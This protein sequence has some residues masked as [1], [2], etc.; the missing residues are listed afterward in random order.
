M[1]QRIKGK[2]RLILALLAMTALFVPAIVM[3]QNELT[4]YDGTVGNYYVPVCASQCDLWLK[5]EYV[6]PADEL[7]DMNGKAITKLKYY[8][9]DSRFWNGMFKV[10]MMEVDYTNYGDSPSFH[11]L[12]GA[13]VV[14]EG[15]LGSTGYP[16]SFREIEL[17]DYYV[18]QGGNL[19]IGVYTTMPRYSNSSVRFYGQTVAGAS[20]QGSGSDANSISISQQNFIPK[21]TFTYI[22][23]DAC[24]RPRDLEYDESSFT[25]S[26]VVLD[27][28]PRGN[29]SSWKLQYSVDEGETWTMV[30]ESITQ[31]PY[32]WTGLQNAT[33]YRVRVCADCGNGIVSEGSSNYVEFFT[34]FC[35]PENQCELHY[36]LSSDDYGWE[37][38]S[39]M[40]YY[41]P[42]QGE[43]IFV[44]E[45][46]L[47]ESYSEG[48][49]F[50][51]D[52][53]TYDFVWYIGEEWWVEAC[54]FVIYGPDGNPIP[55]LDYSNGNLPTGESGEEITLLSDYVMNCPTCK[56]PQ[57]FS[58]TEV[59]AYSASFGWTAGNEESA[60]ELQYSTDQTN[61]SDT[62][63][64]T[65]TPSCS[66]ENLQPATKYYA[67]V[68]ANCG[69]GD[70]S[71]WVKLSFYTECATLTVDETNSYY[72]DFNS[73]I[74]YNYEPWMEGSK[75]KGSEKSNYYLPLCWNSL[76]LGVD[77]VEYY[78][79][80]EFPCIY[81]EYE[82][83][84]NCLKFYVYNY[85]DF[86][87][88]TL[89]QYAVLPTIENVSGLQLSFKAM[90]GESSGYAPFCIGVMTDPADANSFDTIR[91]FAATNE[92]ETFVVYFNHYTGEG[93][94]IAIKVGTPDEWESF[95]LYI[96]DVEVTVQP[97][98]FV[99]YKPEASEIE[100]NEVTLTWE[101]NGDE[102]SW[103]VRYSTDKTNWTVLE[104][105]LQ[106]RSEIVSMQL[107]D[108]QANTL[109]FVQ[110]RAKAG[111]GEYSEWSQM[112]KFRTACS[113]D[114]QAVP[115]YET[116][117]YYIPYEEFPQC[118]EKI[119]TSTYIYNDYPIL[120]NEEGSDDN[121]LYFYNF[122]NN[123][124]NPQDQ[125]AV[126]PIMENISNLQL[127][128]Y[129]MGYQKN[130][131]C[132][133]V[134]IG[135]IDNDD[136]FHTI[137]TVDVNGRAFSS[138][139][140]TFEDYDNESDVGRIAFR[141]NKPVSPYY[142]CTILID[143]VS[144]TEKVDY[145]TFV[146]A[147]DWNEAS[148][149]EN[150]T[151]PSP[152]DTVLVQA[153]AVIPSGCIAEANIID[154]DG[155]NA[156]L[157]IEEGGQLK[158]NGTDMKA[159]LEKTITGYSE[160]EGDGWYLIASP[161]AETKG[162]YYVDSLLNNYY[163]AK[164]DLYRY[165]QSK[166]EME[167]RNYK[168]YDDFIEMVPKSGYLYANQDGVTLY[169]TGTL[170]PTNVDQTVALDFTTG[171][172]HAGWN[173]VGNPFT[174]NAYVSSG[175]YRMN[176]SGTTLESATADT[177]IVPM[178][179][180][181]VKAS[182]VGQTATF[183]TTPTRSEGHL[184]IRLTG[185]DMRSVDNVVVSF[186][187]DSQLGKLMLNPE[188]SKLYFPMD[189]KEY[190]IVS[191]KERSELPLNFKANENG[192][193][194]ISVSIDGTKMN[195]LHLVDNLTGTDVDL[196]TTPVY[197]FDAQTTDNVSRFKLIFKDAT[198][199]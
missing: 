63:T 196:L 11:G 134:V 79:Y 53:G 82:I 10:F 77:N 86:E 58:V 179:G 131:Y 95:I 25:T 198:T 115:Y 109:Y 99:P 43:R 81:D 107:T 102:T 64:V 50:L 128:F 69:G 80:G 169:F 89:D 84:S 83:G 167:W 6:I 130:T 129:G 90:S 157:T 68:R 78:D 19:L 135:V 111:E 70:Y 26:S 61:W 122:R 189:D 137:K 193:Y 185:N 18:Y 188:D 38:N 98:Y 170:F 184:N 113:S 120:G 164:Y 153:A 145:K 49:L 87:E 34:P 106:G 36:E 71:A 45:L 8:Q 158:Q 37:G 62:Q 139:I 195:Y 15:E 108:L 133:T 118:W 2:G 176:S 47:Y 160:G 149:W 175:Y 1:L 32:T 101:P 117:D 29:E 105:S 75:V 7:A 178:E 30:D 46:D 121:Y 156:S 173:L 28:I 136:L 141:V 104:F 125:T 174:C 124:F 76:N 112:N 60:W 3:G 180:V 23:A 116:F 91:T 186:S 94:Y 59:S 57:N 97:T 148:N 72:E 199:E 142:Y 14:Y 190:A 16:Y 40:V 21:T 31:H 66:I 183:T 155:T 22:D 92:L 172:D 44:E 110:V 197:S 74:P 88:G 5:S 161:L 96:D 159:T 146:T 93:E 41:K 191:G 147:G 194:A 100:E 65:E 9:Q 103:Q 166:D 42:A 177:P 187:D 171:N 138:Y 17:D 150:G 54:S 85:D 73:Y 20:V 163:P 27:W 13:T 33:A 48:D 182:T 12:D 126:L 152:T 67:R 39:I 140:I 144:V 35:N 24:W 52:G 55:G 168:R 132:N 51:C 123:S 165:D 119:N 56:K 154:F 181:F 162:C 143:N 127:N 192:R 4:V 114:Y 151:M